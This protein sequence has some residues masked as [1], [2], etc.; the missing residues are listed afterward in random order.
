MVR[1]QTAVDCKYKDAI[2]YTDIPRFINISQFQ[3]LCDNQVAPVEGTTQMI[4][5]NG[6]K[7]MVVYY[8]WLRDQERFTSHQDLTKHAVAI[9]VEIA[10][11]KC[12]PQ[13]QIPDRLAISKVYISELSINV[14][15]TIQEHLK[16]LVTFLEQ[17]STVLRITR[18][19]AYNPQPVGMPRAE[20]QTML[21]MPEVA[22]QEIIPIRSHHQLLDGHLTTGNKHYLVDSDSYQS[23]TFEESDS[24]ALRDALE[25]TDEDQHPPNQLAVHANRADAGTTNFLK[26]LLESQNY[27]QEQD[28]RPNEITESNPV[29][30]P[31]DRCRSCDLVEDQAHMVFLCSEKEHIW[32]TLLDKYTNK[33]NWPEASLLSLLSANHCVFPN[34]AILFAL[35]GPTDLFHPPG[36]LGPT[37]GLPL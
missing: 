21:P 18:S 15:T 30:W 10:G 22:A 32:E 13:I 20:I 19:V 34:E 24:E 28:L 6:S 2:V 36:H 16:H 12:R 9:P 3:A 29:H 23:D 5:K 17:F 26:R 14:N 8:H 4:E 27:P 35:E 7:T 31:T 11:V 25:K 1:N 37:L 33:Y